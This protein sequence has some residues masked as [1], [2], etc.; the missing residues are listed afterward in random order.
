[1]KFI[2]AELGRNKSLSNASD[3]AEISAT[4]SRDVKK[5]GLLSHGG[6]VWWVSYPS[7]W[8][9]TEKEREVLTYLLSM[10]QTLLPETHPGTDQ[11]SHR[12]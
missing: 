10:A 8:K 1:M 7:A 4:N 9:G 11:E 2:Y 6:G 12:R 3:I 5:M